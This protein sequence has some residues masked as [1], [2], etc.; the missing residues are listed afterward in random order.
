MIPG[1]TGPPFGASHPTG[2]RPHWWSL[3]PVPASTKPI[4]ARRG[5]LE[6]IGVYLAFFGPS[7]L[8]AA[9]TLTGYKPTN[10]EGWWVSA[11]NG[12]EEVTQAAL[13]VVVVLLLAQRRGR[14][15]RDV[16]FVLRKATGGPGTSQAIRVAAWA[17]IAFFAGSLIT[18]A[19]ATGSFPFGHVNVAN[20]VLNLS[21][22]ANAG[23]MEEVV[24]VAFL[25]TTLEQARRPRAEIAVVA[26]VCR[27]A[28][29][30]YYGPGAI[31]ILLWAGVFLW[32]FWRFRS[33]VPLI[34]THI[35]WDTLVFLIQVSTAF[36][37]V[38]ILGLLALE[39]TAFILWLVERSERQATMAGWSAGAWS[40]SW[41]APG[42]GPPAEDD[43][44]GP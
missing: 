34:I 30:I 32:L 43:A 2:S 20:T 39:I 22:A 7:I 11:P 37:A 28:Y 21:A 41:V 31:G 19:L 27:G 25:V 12:F 23:V 10:P 42:W 8:V 38:L 4:S 6:A 26:L 40:G 33:V 3:A 15:P 24:V 16:G 14:S 1:S 36:S 17:A 44:H 35:A 29:H 9:G 13:A 18:S 5:Y